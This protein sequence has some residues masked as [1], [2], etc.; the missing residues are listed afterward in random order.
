MTKSFKDLTSIEYTTGD[1][2]EF[3]RANPY[4]LEQ[5]VK[6]YKHLLGDGQITIGKLS[7]F[8]SHFPKEISISLADSSG[9]GELK[10]ENIE[11]GWGDLI[12]DVS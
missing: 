10:A 3:S 7:E 4:Y 6:M 12:F 8:L 5:R 2:E 1:W 11:V 9:Y